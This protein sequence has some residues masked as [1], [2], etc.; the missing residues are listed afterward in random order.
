[1]GK[2]SKKIRTKI[3][4][5][6]K[7]RVV[8]RVRIIVDSNGRLLLPEIYERFVRMYQENRFVPTPVVQWKRK[9]SILKIIN[10]S[11]QLEVS[12]DLG[13]DI[14]VIEWGTRYRYRLHPVMLIP[15]QW[16]VMGVYK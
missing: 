1:M 8:K 15:N 5:L 9:D 6:A 10:G 11:F 2:I 12:H 3:S 14:E 13:Y 7:A 4:A 16:D